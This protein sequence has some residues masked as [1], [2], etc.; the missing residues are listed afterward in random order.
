VIVG[1]LV[2]RLFQFAGASAGVEIAEARI[3]ALAMLTN[4]ERGAARDP[5]A[6]VDSAIELWR[7]MRERPDV[8]ALFAGGRPLYEIPFSLLDGGAARILRGTIDCLIQRD[9]GSVTVVEFKTGARRAVH[10][11]QLAVY[12]RAARRLFPGAAVDSLLISPDGIQDAA[13]PS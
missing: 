10:E 12:V 8:A 9:D 13:A 11:Q 2:H 4:D 5:G 6:V 1:R 3:R 7:G